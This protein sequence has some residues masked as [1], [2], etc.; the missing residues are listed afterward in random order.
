MQSP[1][2]GDLILSEHLFDPVGAVVLCMLWC[3][4]S[5]IISFVSKLARLVRSEKLLQ[6]SVSIWTCT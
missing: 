3:F 1:T 2:H 5:I 6:P 4:S